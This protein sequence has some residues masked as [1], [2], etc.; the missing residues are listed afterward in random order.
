MIIASSLGIPSAFAGLG[1]A[2]S[3]PGWI[4][5]AAA[6]ITFCVTLGAGM[7]M[8]NRFCESP[9]NQPHNPRSKNTPEGK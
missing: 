6:L 7:W 9:K 4:I 3:A 2:V 1:I 5:V 8:L